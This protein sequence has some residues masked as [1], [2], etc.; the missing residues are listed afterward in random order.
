MF[1]L[2]SVAGSSAATAY[3]GYDHVVDVVDAGADDT[4]PI[5]R[6]QRSIRL[7]TGTDILVR[8]AEVTITSPQSTSHALSVLDFCER[9]RIQDVDIRIEG[10]DTN[11]GIVV[12]P[13]AGE[14]D[15]TDTEIVHE[16][17]GGYSLWIR[18]SDSREQVLVSR[19][20]VRGRAGAASGF[21]DRHPL[22]AEQL[23]V[24]RYRRRSA[25]MRRRRAK[26]A[27]ADW[28]RLDGVPGL[29]HGKPVPVHRSRH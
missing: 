13:Q 20:A 6:S 9:A 15:I 26:R 22:R 10:D 3:D 14:V 27:R 8:G 7:E 19:V 17:A 24:Y 16:T 25:G 5:D 4:G 12:S 2:L 1:G 23:P 21:R 18:E 29:A 11:H 28:H